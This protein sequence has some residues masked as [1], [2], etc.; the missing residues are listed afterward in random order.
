MFENYRLRKEKGDIVIK[1]EDV[2][3]AKSDPKHQ[4]EVS[5]VLYNTKGVQNISKIKY[6]K[7]DIIA[8]KESLERKL[9][10]VLE[11]LDDLK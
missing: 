6:T 10:G 4:F 1:K 8:L 11:M 7:E 5:F 3:K 2:D 9:S